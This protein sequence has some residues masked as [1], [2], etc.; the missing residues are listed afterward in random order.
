[1]PPNTPKYL[2]IVDA[3][4]NCPKNKTNKSS[5]LRKQKKEP[6]LLPCNMATDGMLG[7]E[8]IRELDKSMDSHNV[9]TD[10]ITSQ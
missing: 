9:S 3:T 5:G 6:S 2:K 10:N 4:N 1:M 8:A 7:V